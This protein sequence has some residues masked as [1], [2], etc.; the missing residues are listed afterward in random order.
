MAVECEFKPC[1]DPPDGLLVEQIERLGWQQLCVQ[2]CVANV[3]VVRE[4]Y[5]NAHYNRP[6]NVVLVRGKDVSF[7]PATIRRLF[8][9]PTVDNDVFHRLLNQGADYD[10][11]LQEMGLPAARW[12]YSINNPD[13]PVNVPANVFNRFAHAWF[14]FIRH[15]LIPTSQRYEITTDR[16]L[17]MYC[18]CSGRSIDVATIIKDSICHR[19]SLGKNKIKLPHAIL[20]IYLCAQA[21]VPMSDAEMTLGPTKFDHDSLMRFEQWSGGTPQPDGMGFVP[22]P[23]RPAVPPPPPV[24]PRIR[25]APPVGNR[26]HGPAID[27]VREQRQDLRRSRRQT[28]RG[29]GSSSSAPAPE[30]HS[31]DT[32][33]TMMAH[34]FETLTLVQDRLLRHVSDL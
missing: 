23:D 32:I 9:L 18:I 1:A 3:V 11:I 19:A 14:H 21:G 15:N 6:G 12:T 8:G 13:R 24:L 10:Q 29:E 7:S 5:A 25:H 28:Q 33:A 16:V 17:L 4:F 26:I 31:F 27:D 22:F 20:I 34:G 2:K 30:P